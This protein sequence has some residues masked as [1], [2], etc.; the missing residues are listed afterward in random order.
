MT[1]DDLTVEGHRFSGFY[2]HSIS[3]SQFVQGEQFEAVASTNQSLLGAQSHKGLDSLTSA[4]HGKSLQ[5][6]GERKQEEENRPFHG[7][8]HVSCPEGGQD[9]QQVDIDRAFSQRLP[10]GLDSEGA[11]RD[12]GQS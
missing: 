10:G 2:N 12:I 9:H 4:V 7:G 11:A 1:F 8:V 6:I 5:H 3:G